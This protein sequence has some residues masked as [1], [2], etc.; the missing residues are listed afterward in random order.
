MQ[1]REAYSLLKLPHATLSGKTVGTETGQLS[2]ECITMSSNDAPPTSG[3]DRHVYL[4]FKVN[5]MEYPLDPERV[6]TCT[7][8][9][10]IRAFRLAGTPSDPAEL[11]LSIQVAA[12]DVEGNDKLDAFEN[13][14]E[15]YVVEYRGPGGSSIKFPEPQTASPQ[16]AGL[17]AAKGNNDLRGHLVMVNE[18]TGEVLGAVED[19]FRIKED[20]AMHTA[21]AGHQNDTV[22]IEVPDNIL[23]GRES[24]AAAL[25][26][27]ATLI[28]PDQ[29]NWISKSA[30]IVRQVIRLY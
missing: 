5:A 22:L 23:T 20:P 2:L 25:E 11:Q 4:V 7:H 28:P 29:Q 10:G 12:A 26:A 24:D 13:I 14:L 17:G 30:G 9:P 21:G 15:Q 3:E 27:F 18:D 16:T 1:L 6:V 19:R 8:Q